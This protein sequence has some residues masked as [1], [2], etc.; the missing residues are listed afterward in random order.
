MPRRWDAE[1]ALAS[2][3]GRFEDDNENHPQSGLNRRAAKR[4]GAR[5][6]FIAAQSAIA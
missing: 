1:T 3:D 5:R 4:K 2:I 6:G